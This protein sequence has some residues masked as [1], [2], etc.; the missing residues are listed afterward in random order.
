MILV[1]SLELYEGGRLMSYNIYL[2]EDE[3]NLN[4][5]L[6][7]YLMNEGWHVLSFTT[8]DEAKKHIEDKPHLWILDIML[9]DGSGY[10]FIKE[11]KHTYEETPVIFISARDQSFDR[12]LGLELGSDDYLPKPFLP[13]ELVVRSQKILERVYGKTNQ[14]KK[15]T[16]HEIGQYVIT[17]EH[18]TVT[19]ND[20]PIELTSLEFDLVLNFAQNKNR[21]FSRDALLNSVWGADYFGKDRV[22]DDLIRRVR[23]KLPDFPIETVYGYGYRLAYS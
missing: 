7:T 23:K 21:V 4:E 18:R 9:P 17:E 19:C 20:Q 2:L 15:L 22:V 14:E 12:L 3:E 5:I 11:V 10:D 6:T 8:V 16:I 13:K 1:K